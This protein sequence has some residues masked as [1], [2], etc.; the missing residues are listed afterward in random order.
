MPLRWE[1]LH[2]QKLVIVIGE[3]DVTLKDVEVYLDAIVTAGA[4]PYGKLFDATDLIPKYGDH[5]VM[6]LGAR[7]SAYIDTLKGGALAFVSTNPATR[8]IIER[9]L[10]LAN[11]A[12]RATKI[13]GTVDE[14]KDWLAAQGKN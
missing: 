5:D 11:K 1:I 6:M 4:M 12:P 3:G 8:D 10:N 9:Y 13:F 2:P 7:I 14:A